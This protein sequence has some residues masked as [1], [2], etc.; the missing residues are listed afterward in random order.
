MERAGCAHDIGFPHFSFFA[1]KFFR[2]FRTHGDTNE[3]KPG[4]SSDSWLLHPDCSVCVLI[5]A[6][7]PLWRLACWKLVSSYSSATVPGF[8]G[9]SCVG[10]L[11][12]NSQRTG[13]DYSQPGTKIK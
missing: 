3:S 8:H 7:A 12:Y 13:A 9:I 10:L 4:K 2:V 5:S 6:F 1:K 11:L